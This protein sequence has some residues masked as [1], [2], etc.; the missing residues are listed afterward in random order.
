MDNFVFCV[1][2]Y[3]NY[4]HFDKNNFCQ[5]PWH[6]P[7]DYVI[8]SPKREINTLR[9][10]FMVYYSHLPENRRTANVKGR[11]LSWGKAPYPITRKWGSAKIVFCGGHDMCEHAL[12]GRL[13]DSGAFGDKTSHIPIIRVQR[14]VQNWQIILSYQSNITPR[15]E[16]EISAFPPIGCALRR[17][18]CARHTETACEVSRDCANICLLAGWPAA[19]R[20]ASTTRESICFLTKWF[21]ARVRN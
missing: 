6:L 5:F 2:N 16:L 20:A 14:R 10:L 1:D 21:P 19:A 12:T 4:P 11:S 17:R 8:L 18:C 13:T 3:K 15:A 9:F 7:Q